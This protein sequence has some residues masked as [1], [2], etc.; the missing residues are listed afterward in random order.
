M[1][2]RPIPRP[3]QVSPRITTM[4]RQERRLPIAGL[5]IIRY[6]AASRAMTYHLAFWSCAVGHDATSNSITHGIPAF[7]SLTSL[8]WF[9]GVGV[10]IFFVLSCFVILYSAGRDSRSFARSRVLRLVPGALVSASRSAGGLLILLKM[11][12]WSVA[13]RFLD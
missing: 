12:V 9:G 1:L 8:S 11:P 10:D 4:A 7:P 5:D 2:E 3:A 6:L 13:T